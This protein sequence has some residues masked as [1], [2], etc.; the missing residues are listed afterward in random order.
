VKLARLL[1]FPAMA[2]SKLD[3]I[4]EAP[5]EKYVQE[6]PKQVAPA[7]VNR[8]LATL[9]FALR[10][11]HEW[12]AIDRLPKVGLLQGERTREFLLSREQE[13]QYLKA[14]PQ[15][16]KTSRSSCLTRACGTARRWL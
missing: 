15:P 7:M 9:R 16:L 14:A 8:R 5:I 13:P 3:A 1:E 11:A 10:L 2:N 4:D 6:R 12:K